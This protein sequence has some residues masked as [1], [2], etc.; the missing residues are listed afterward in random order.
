MLT[1]KILIEAL[2]SLILD[3]LNGEDQDSLT[4][5]LVNTFELDEYTIAKI[6]GISD[7]QLDG[8]VKNATINEVVELVNKIAR[9]EYYYDGEI[10]IEERDIETYSLGLLEKKLKEKQKIDDNGQIDIINI[11]LK[12]LIEDI[13]QFIQELKDRNYGVKGVE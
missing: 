7:D 11:S 4:S 13:L 2:K 1:K 8:L 9:D 3:F 6:D 10:E 5:Y 12:E